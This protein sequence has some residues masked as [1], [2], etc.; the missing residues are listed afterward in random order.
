VRVGRHAVGDE[1]LAVLLPDELLFGGAVLLAS[2]LERHAQE[3]CSVVSLM[4]V[5]PE[6]ISS[7]GCARLASGA[8]GGTLSVT[9]CVEK[10]DATEA[11]S[12]YA[13]CGRYVLDIDVLDELESTEPDYRGE[14]QLTAALD[15]AASRREVIGIELL[16]QDGR[17][18]IGNWTGWLAANR[19]AFDP[20]DPAAPGP[21]SDRR[22][23]TA[24]SSPNR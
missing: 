12:N 19:R 9:G 3:A 6:E 23:E 1:P 13:I 20:G 24:A 10:P 2:M 11:P 18:D 8:T 5:Q 7:Y 4:Q 22:T 17:I 15:A 16:T 21:T 14:V